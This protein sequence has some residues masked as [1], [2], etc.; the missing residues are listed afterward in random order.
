[1]PT[2]VPSRHPYRDRMIPKEQVAKMFNNMSGT[3]VFLIMSYAGID[4]SG[5]KWP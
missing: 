5:G 2:L 4:E 1:M 3:Y